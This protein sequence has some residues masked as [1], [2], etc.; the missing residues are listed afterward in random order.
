MT[1]NV[2]KSENTGIERSSA[3]QWYPVCFFFPYLF[4]TN[5]YLHKDTGLLATNTIHHCEHRAQDASRAFFFSFTFTTTPG[6]PRAQKG[7]KRHVSWAGVCS[8]FFVSV[9]TTNFLLI[10]Y[11]LQVQ[12]QPLPLMATQATSVGEVWFQTDSNSV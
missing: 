6:A 5:N 9:F 7:P 10:E 12:P 3:H 1:R 4:F 2:Q 11:G 8:F